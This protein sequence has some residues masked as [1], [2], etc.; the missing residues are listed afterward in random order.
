MKKLYTVLFALVVFQTAFAQEKPKTPIGGR[1]NIPS[2][3]SFEFGFNQLNNRPEDMGLNFFRSRTFNA[4]FQ[5]PIKI[6]G[7]TSGMTFDPGIGFGT[8]KYAFKDGQNLFVDASKGSESSKLQDVS[9][10]FGDD[11]NLKTNNL[12]ANYIDIPLD[13]TYHLNK[14]NHYKGFH[15]SLGAKIGYLYEAHTK[16][17]FTDSDGVKRKVKDS[18]N[19]GLEKF[20]YGLTFKAGSP[21]FYAWMYYGLNNIFK[22][23]MGPVSTQATQIN[24]GV[25]V[26]VF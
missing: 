20:R 26:N 5:H 19:Y 4:Y 2:N 11:I 3:L 15:V 24:F 6:F 16:I 18:Q 21:G 17:K 22:D 7:E 8:D 12:A 23:G 13:F 10:E 14:A 9:E 1:P 25:A